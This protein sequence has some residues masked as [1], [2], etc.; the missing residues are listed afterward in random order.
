MK[1]CQGILSRVP[2]AE[3]GQTYSIFSIYLVH[4]LITDWKDYRFI[5][6]TEKRKDCYL[7]RDGGKNCLE[8][9]SLLTQIIYHNL[10]AHTGS[11]RTAAY[12]TGPIPGIALLQKTTSLLLNKYCLVSNEDQE[13]YFCYSKSYAKNPLQSIQF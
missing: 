5:K 6:H 10:A 1:N 13:P 8:L 7:K 11:S 3:G 12:V 4:L 2:L 9:I